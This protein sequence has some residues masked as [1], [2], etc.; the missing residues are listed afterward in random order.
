M[1]LGL[2][3]AILYSFMAGICMDRWKCKRTWKLG[4]AEI[5]GV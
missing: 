5:S 4:M 1:G 2:G 3:P